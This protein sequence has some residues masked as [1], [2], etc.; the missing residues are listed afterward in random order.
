M[1]KKEFPR[2]REAFA[3]LLEELELRREPPE[4]T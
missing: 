1:G 3:E 4:R 2:I